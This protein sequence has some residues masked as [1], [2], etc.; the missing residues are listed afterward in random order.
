MKRAGLFFLLVFLGVSGLCWPSFQN[1]C[2]WGRSF[3]VSRSRDQMA[4]AEVAANDP[5]AAMREA[6]AAKV[7]EPG[8]LAKLALEAK[9]VGIRL[10]AAGK[11]TDQ[12]VLA[13]VA[14]KDADVEVRKAV[15]GRLTMQ[16]VLAEV[17]ANDPNEDVKKA[18]V[19]SLHLSAQ[20]DPMLLERVAKVAGNE[21]IRAAVDV[22]MNA[23]RTI[24]VMEHRREEL[25]RRMAE[26][27]DDAALA[28]AAISHVDP[29]I[30]HA[31]VARLSDQTALAKVAVESRDW[32]VVRTAWAKVTDPVLCRTL[33]KDW[34]LPGA[35]AEIEVSV[36]LGTAASVAL[37]WVPPTLGG[38]FSMGS[39]AGEEYRSNDDTQHTV[40]LTKGFWFGRTEVTQG[41]WEAVMESNPSEFKGSNLP[42][43]NVSWK[44]SMAFCRKLTERERAAGRLPD[45]YEYTL[46]TEAQWEYACRAGSVGAYAGDLDAIAWYGNN[47]GNRTHPAG[48]KLPNAWG[49]YDM[50]GNVWEWCRDWYGDY[51]GGT[52]TD[53]AGPSQGSLRVCRGG[54]WY[55][56]ASRCRSA[57][58]DGYYPGYRIYD[59]GFR[60]VLAPAPS[61]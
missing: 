60:L 17:A 35:G 55:N 48:T 3:A 6:A 10:G 4:L 7:T 15:L 51:P 20:T 28:Q 36:N 25:D 12:E 52:V 29:V 11:I 37:L 22:R 40:N 39:P 38:G 53:P 44:D 18:A 26:F 57:L 16:S 1:P 49:L 45:G 2:P 13:K 32:G 5:N 56:V 21:K 8:P 9:D 47:S 24:E 42:V 23:I 61:P 33:A 54:S 34:G 41:Q 27:P 59:L 46:P 30:R 31:A 58:R 19:R 50:H 14:L 43:E